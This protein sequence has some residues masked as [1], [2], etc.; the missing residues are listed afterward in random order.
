MQRVWVVLV[1]FTGCLVGLGANCTSEPAEFGAGDDDATSSSGETVIITE[2]MANPSRVS[3]QD[4]EWFEIY[5][6]GA[7]AVDMVGWTISDAGG[8]TFTFDEEELI[9]A[10]RSYAVLGVND[11]TEEN[12]GVTLDYVYPGEFT[13][14]NSGDSIIIENADGVLVDAVSYDKAPDGASLSLS[15]DKYDTA[16]NDNED[17]FCATRFTRMPGGDLG[18]PGALNDVCVIDASPGDLVITEIMAFPAADIGDWG[19]YVEIYNTTADDIRL[20]GW[21]LADGAGDRLTIS[22]N[23]ELTVPALGYVVIGAH[24]ESS[25]NGGVSIDYSW[26]STI[27]LNETSDT[28]TISADGT[29]VDTVTYGQGD[30]PTMTEGV[31]IQLD[32]SAYDAT[33]N[34]LGANWC[35]SVTELTSGEKG[36]PGE[37]NSSCS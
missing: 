12:G 13:L 19:K 3:D 31:S 11:R 14:A 32:P 30:F 17:N 21:V 7:E 34:D 8:N 36:T 20:D 6:P 24:F 26:G 15:P 29:T 1:A 25:E 4:G 23:G 37:R 18:T 22:S 33:M 2:I 10:A 35:Q 16:A 5:N 9:V 28:I 27:V